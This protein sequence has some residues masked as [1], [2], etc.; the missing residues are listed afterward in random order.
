VARSGE[1]E[2]QASSLGTERAGSGRTGVVEVEAEGEGRGRLKS[3]AEAWAWAAVRLGGVGAPGGS[4][5]WSL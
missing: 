2:K 1:E 5:R 3:V 4:T